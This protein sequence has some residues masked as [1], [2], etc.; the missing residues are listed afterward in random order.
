MKKVERF[1][2]ERTEIATAI[3]FKNDYAVLEIDV[4]NVIEM[5]GQVVGYRGCKVRQDFGNE[6]YYTGTINYWKDEKKLSV[7][8]DNA[9]IKSGFGYRD[10]KEMLENRNAP[11]IKNGQKAILVAYNSKTGKVLSPMV[12]E[13]EGL[14][15]FVTGITLLDDISFIEQ[16]EN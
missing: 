2:S 4:A 12:F 1:L 5:C 13:I 11:I 7:S 3:N 14:Q 10:I 16:L 8:S 6:F 9:C 15:R